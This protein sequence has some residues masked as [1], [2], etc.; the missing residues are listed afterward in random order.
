[1][2]IEVTPTGHLQIK[3]DEGLRYVLAPGEDVS[4]QPEDVQNT[5]AEVWTA[6]ILADHQARLAAQ[7]QDDPTPPVPKKISRWQFYYGL[8]L[9][10]KITDDE[11]LAAVSSGAIPAAIEAIVDAIPDAPAKLLAKMLLVSATDFYRSHALIATFAAAEGM[12]EEDVDNFW[13]LCASIQ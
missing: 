6:Q 5:A 8:F 1:M 12:T 9:S 10:G 13:R 3:T 11:A 2:I 7:R 4:D